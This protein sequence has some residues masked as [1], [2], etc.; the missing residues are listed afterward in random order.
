MANGLHHENEAI[1]TLEKQLSLL[2]QASLGWKD[3]AKEEYKEAWKR[4]KKKEK[5]VSE[6]IEILKTKLYG[7]EENNI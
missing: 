3:S 4:V 5:E 2:E 1:A 6:A 7:K